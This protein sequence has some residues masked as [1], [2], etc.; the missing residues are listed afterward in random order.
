MQ[1]KVAWNGKMQLH[2]HIILGE[3][4]DEYCNIKKILPMKTMIY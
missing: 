2:V 4:G 3:N 1:S